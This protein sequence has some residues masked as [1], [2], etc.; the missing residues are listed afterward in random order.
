M[1]IKKIALWLCILCI[2]SFSTS[3]AQENRNVGDQSDHVS[4]IPSPDEN[5]VDT[6]PDHRKL[7]VTD[8]SFLPKEKHSKY[9][10]YGMGG[11]FISASGRIMLGDGSQ[12]AEM[13][14]DNLPMLHPVDGYNIAL[15][16]KL[17]MALIFKEES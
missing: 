2:S 5:E 3:W 16:T 14:S 1:K 7:N 4:Q 12:Y 10:V 11:G 8:E 17:W 9:K 13:N 6:T 15:E